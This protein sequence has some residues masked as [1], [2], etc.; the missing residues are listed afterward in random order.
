MHPPARTARQPPC[1]ARPTHLTARPPPAT[2]PPGP[3]PPTPPTARPPPATPAPQKQA[4][5]SP[6]QSR[7]RRGLR[8]RLHD[9]ERKVRA[10]SGGRRNGLVFGQEPIEF[11]AG[12]VPAEALAGP[13]VE[14][15]FDVLE[16][17]GGVRAEVGALGEVFAQQPVDVLVAAALPGCVRVGE[18]DAD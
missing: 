16:L 18:E 6:R 15:V 14:L 2:H 11:L 7:G 17:G 5:Q 8:L 12:G 10:Y 3:A 4:S 1:A 9:H 13:V